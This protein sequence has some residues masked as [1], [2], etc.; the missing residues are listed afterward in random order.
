MRIAIETGT[1]SPW[2]SR[3]LAEAGHEVLVANARELGFIYKNSRKNDRLDAE[4]LQSGACG[5]CT[6]ASYSPAFTAA[7]GDVAQNPP[8]NI[9]ESVDRPTVT[10]RRL[11]RGAM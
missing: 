9:G 3:L 11:P 6:C 5:G 4:N 7:G 1:H 8:S 10:D 2:V